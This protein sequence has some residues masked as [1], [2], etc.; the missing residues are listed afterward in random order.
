MNYFEKTRNDIKTYV[1]S[2][3]TPDNKVYQDNELLILS[4]FNKAMELIEENE[5]LA[6]GK[7]DVIGSV[8]VGCGKQTP[9]LTADNNCC[10]ECWLT[11]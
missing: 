4:C 11:K 5:S 3:N 1:R 10:D 9:N 6:L 2:L 8:C 7:T